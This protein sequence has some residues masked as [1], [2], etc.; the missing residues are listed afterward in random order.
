MLEDFKTNDIATKQDL[1]ITI[2]EDSLSWKLL[3]SIQRPLGVNFRTRS[4]NDL[5]QRPH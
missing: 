5:I 4:D 2:K 3:I 1:S